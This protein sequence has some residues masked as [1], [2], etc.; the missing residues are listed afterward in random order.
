M[1]AAT[2]RRSTA[3]ATLTRGLVAVLGC[4][5]LA[6]RPLLERAWPGGGSVLL[7]GAL[8]A[9][10][11]ALPASREASAVPV[12]RSVAL[13][14]GIGAFLTARLVTGGVP[15][16]AASGLLLA[17]SVL[18]AVAEE[19]FFRRLSFG[20]FSP[21]GPGYAIVA[22]AVLFAA[23]HVGTYGV[24]VLP[25]DLAAGLLLGW[26]RWSTGSWTVPAVTHAVANLLVLL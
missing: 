2:L 6:S 4:A 23:V 9:V 10:S 15:P 8:L 12:G 20:L 11:C 16:A 13:A 18:A 17:T 7:F 26:Q 21:A 22:T 5:P 24:W 1:T 25:L 14:V 3:G 19:A